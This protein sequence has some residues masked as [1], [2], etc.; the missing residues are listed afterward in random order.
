MSYFKK[1]T[2]YF[3]PLGG[4]GEIGM[5][6]NM[7]GYNNQWVIIDV[8]VS[9]FKQFGV[10]VVMPD[11][12]FIEKIKD[13]VL[14]IFITHAHEDHLGALAHLWEHIQA[15]VYLTPFTNYIAQH[16]LKEAGIKNADINK[17]K[18]G[19]KLT[20]GPFEV[21]FVHLT[22]STLEP[23]GLVLRTPAG[24]IFHTGDWKFDI[25]PL[26]GS[27][28]DGSQLKA[29][30][31]EGVL[32]LVCDSTNVFEEGESGSESL[33]RESLI[34]L[35]KHQ[36]NRVVVACF[37]SNLARVQS[38]L[39][40][41]KESGRKVALVGRS[42]KHMVKGAAETNYFGDILDHVI[43]EKEAADLPRDKVMYVC[44]GSQGESRSALKRISEGS[45]HH[46]HLEEDDTVIF[47]SRIIPGNEKDIA[48]MHNSLARTGVQVLTH[49]EAAFVHV[50]GH[51]YRDELKQM[52]EWVRPKVL[53][54]VHGED[55]HLLEHA[56]YAT[57]E[58]AVPHAVVPHNGSLIEFQKDKAHIVEEAKIRTG[59]W[60]RDGFDLIEMNGDIMHDRRK[61]SYH[62]LVAASIAID[63]KLR[64]KGSPEVTQRGIVE[65]NDAGDFCALIEERIEKAVKNQPK[66]ASYKDLQEAV[67]VCIRQFINKARGIK[68]KIVLHIIEL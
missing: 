17:V 68:P 29:L 46:I 27:H 50:S 52:Y 60:G 32:A 45:H 16:K 11:I 8:G 5:N 22:H 26:V 4:C 3:L 33:V 6:L 18:L 7:Y 21:E 34:D 37:A 62:G 10:E 66:D 48:T 14:G 63:G 1:D 12:S 13:Q 55:R 43:S 38:A 61:L 58:C 57:E 67:R 28:F 23:N 39:E 49:R 65:G 19:S 36:K 15:P 9:F 30:G 42:M 54:P 24:T 2:L 56:R 47:S 31:D 41:A 25:D 64:L 20:K 53:I 44:T 40:A 35:V 59:Y 51:P